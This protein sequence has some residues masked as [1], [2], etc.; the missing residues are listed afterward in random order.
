MVPPQYVREPGIGALARPAEAP[1]CPTYPDHAVLCLWS[2]VQYGRDVAPVRPEQ[3]P[4]SQLAFIGWS[5]AHVVDAD[6][7]GGRVFLT[8]LVVRGLW[9]GTPPPGTWM[10]R[11]LARPP[12][13]I[14]RERWQR[15]NLET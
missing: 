1:P 4:L 13:R 14:A 9:H 10:R 12:S 5:G 7:E 11:G 2:L 8:R 3:H 15:G 6:G